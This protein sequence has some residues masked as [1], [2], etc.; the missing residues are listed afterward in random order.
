MYRLQFFRDVVLMSVTPKNLLD[1]SQSLIGT[2]VDE[3]TVR[4]SIGRSY[5]AAFH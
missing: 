1:L 4:C 5:Y 2:A 3:A